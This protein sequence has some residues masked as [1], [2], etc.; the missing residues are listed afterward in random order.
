M[1]FKHAYYAPE[2]FLW[3]KT[4]SPIWIVALNPKERPGYSTHT[5]AELE[6]YFDT[7]DKTL[8]FF[9]DYGK[10]S[11][12]LF[13]LLGRDNGAI[14]TDIVKCF[15]KKFPP[16]G[17]S[18]KEIKEI[19]GN[20]KPYFE[21]QLRKWT[22]KLIVCNGRAVC[23]VVKGIIKPTEESETSYY[24]TYNGADIIVVLSG[25]IGRIDNYAKR[26]L[27]L[28]IEQYMGKLGIT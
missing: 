2:D 27:G 1:C 22:P 11:P 4:S 8:S 24:G 5:V 3:G 19:I 26:R 7:E 17:C 10:V 25:F 28:E 23:D 9:E 6:R 16:E 20:C 15:S 18:G 12:K 13:E 14:H 21:K